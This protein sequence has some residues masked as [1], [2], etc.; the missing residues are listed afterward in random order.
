MEEKDRAYNAFFREKF[1]HFSPD[2]PEG[3]WEHIRQKMQPSA[4]V[5]QD[6]AG[7]FLSW[8][9]LKYFLYPAMIILVAG[10]IFLL[11]WQ[12]APSAQIHGTAYINGDTLTKGTAFLFH[13]SDHT[14]PLDSV[15]WHATSPLDS[16]GSF[17]FKDLPHGKYMVRIHV[18]THS[19]CYP[20][21]Q[22]GYHGDTLQWDQ[23]TIIDTRDPATEANVTIPR[24]SY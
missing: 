3:S 15:R 18:D 10:L 9:R 24:I 4:E 1:S 7:W 22:F 20:E 14:R 19:S 12:T 2:P 23:S 8:I 5:C 6:P 11:V 17:H 13:V 21:Y 16:S